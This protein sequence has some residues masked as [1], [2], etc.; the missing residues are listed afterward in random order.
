MY[1]LAQRVI[2]IALVS[3]TAIAHE[4][5]GASVVHWHAWDHTLITLLALLAGAIAG[6]AFYAARKKINKN[7]Y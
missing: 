5:H 2:C 3:T 6:V 1:R 7:K 4:G